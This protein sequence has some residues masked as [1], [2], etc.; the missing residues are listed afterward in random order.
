MTSWVVF[1]H[2]DHPD[3]WG[4]ARD[5]SFWDMT[6]H[7]KIELGDTVYFWQAGASLVAQ[8]TATTSAYPITSTDRQPWD[9]TGTR[10]YKAR[11]E[12]DCLSEEPTAQPRW[13][14]LRARWGHEYYPRLRSFADPAEEK[15]LAQYF[16]TDPIA[17]PYRDAER[18]EEMKRLGFDNRTFSLRSIAQRQG[19][20]AFRNRLLTAYGRQ[21][22]VTGTTA[23]SVLEA[24]H[25]ARYLGPQ[26]NRTSNGLLLRADIHTLFDLHQLTV[27]RKYI[28][29]VD[30][31][32]EDTYDKFDGVELGL[33]EKSSEHPAPELLE[34]HNAE[35]DWL[36]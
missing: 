36:P 14:E 12:F 31:R 3:H 34:A 32:L 26:S 11:F 30:P 13:Q 33:P 1:I 10:T 6:S 9:D 17:D 23:V 7:F 35:C 21:C 2:A 29:R 24:A 19:Q 4:I 28:V 18:D 15:V 25:I 8:C 5:A 16:A 22:A 27:T 20:Q